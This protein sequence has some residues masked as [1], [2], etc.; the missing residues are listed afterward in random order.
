MLYSYTIVRMKPPFGLPAPYAVGY[1]DLPADGLRIFALLD[2][3]IDAYR[4]G[5]PLAL[6]SGPLGV[7]LAG[8][9][10]ARP[11]FTPAEG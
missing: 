10:C 2:P 1:V 8:A 4:I 6:T 7:D 11:F 9:P 5:M 3:T